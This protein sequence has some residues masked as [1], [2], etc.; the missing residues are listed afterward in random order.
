[1]TDYC[2]WLGLSGGAIMIYLNIV[3]FIRG[4]HIKRLIK[5]NEKPYKS[6]HDD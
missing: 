5:K 4:E 1:M 3:I 6:I 2:I